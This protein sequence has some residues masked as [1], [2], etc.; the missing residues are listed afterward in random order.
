M[1]GNHSSENIKLNALMLPCSNV[2]GNKKGKKYW[3]KGKLSNRDDNNSI[4]LSLN[5]R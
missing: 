4:K 5:Y 2:I 1:E 3:V